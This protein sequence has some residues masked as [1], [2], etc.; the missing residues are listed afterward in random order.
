MTLSHPTTVLMVTHQL[1][2]AEQFCNRVVYVNQGQIA[3]EQA[4]KVAD[5]Q[6][7]HQDMLE[8]ERQAAEQ[9]DNPDW[10]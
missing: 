4:A 2:L 8:T 1:D 7:I 6:Q 5:W 10:S 3:F 9:W